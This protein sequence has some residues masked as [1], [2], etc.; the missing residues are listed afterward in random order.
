MR[1]A[2]DLEIL[3]A[4]LLKERTS[5]RL[6]GPA[7]AELKVRSP[8]GLDQLPGL[9]ARLGGR[10]APLGSGTNIIA[11]DD[12]LPVLLV[13]RTPL[14]AA[15]VLRENGPR[16]LLRADAALRL[17]AL[18]AE[19]ASLGLTGLEELTGVPGSVGG[20]TAMNAGSYGLSIGERVHSVEVFTPSLGLTERP[21][22]DFVFSYRS[23]RLRGHEDWFLISAVTLSLGKGERE[24]IREHMREIYLKKRAGQPVTARSA[25]CVFKNPSPETPAGRLLEKAGL[26]GMR[27]GGMRFSPVHAN[28]LVNEGGGSFEQALYLIELA[29]ERVYRD[30]GHTL[31]TEVRLWP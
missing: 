8:Q 20:A 30:S 14:H 2:Q 11:H 29:R 9:A 4:P 19:A 18:L 3:K 5:I 17:P 26:K 10:L 25:G 28:F 15:R 12:A 13:T 31:E 1:T 23:C 24:R 27:M 7:I 16:V 22:G 6:G 21:A